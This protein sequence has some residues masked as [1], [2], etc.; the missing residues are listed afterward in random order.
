MKKR[1]LKTFLKIIWVFI[2]KLPLLIIWRLF[3]A[4]GTLIVSVNYLFPKE[5]GKDRNV[6]KSA[7][8]YRNVGVMAPIY[9]IVFYIGLILMFSG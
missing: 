8:D 3:C 1:Y 2:I 9:S 7:R 6:A 5:W 4:P